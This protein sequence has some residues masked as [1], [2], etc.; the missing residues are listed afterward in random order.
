MQLETRAPRSRNDGMVT[1]LT[2]AI[3]LAILA[4]LNAGCLAPF[5]NSLDVAPLIRSSPAFSVTAGGNTYT[6][7]R[8]AVE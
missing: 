5:S 7:R 2:L 8:V 1:R 4:G 3:G 6:G